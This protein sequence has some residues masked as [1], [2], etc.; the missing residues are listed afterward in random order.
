[1]IMDMKTFKHKIRKEIM[2]NIIEQVHKELNISQNG[3]K[4]IVL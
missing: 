4:K 1:M 3:T 2:D